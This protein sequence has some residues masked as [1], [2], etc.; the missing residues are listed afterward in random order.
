MFIELYMDNGFIVLNT[1]HIVSF[2]VDE[3]ISE[4]YAKEYTTTVLYIKTIDGVTHRNSFCHLEEKESH[5]DAVWNYNKLKK[6]LNVT[7]EID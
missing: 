3:E 5:A 2:H 6:M 1:M 7:L 4:F